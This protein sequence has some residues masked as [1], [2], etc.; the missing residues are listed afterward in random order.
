MRALKEVSIFLLSVIL[1]CY[2]NIS[3]PAE[4]QCRVNEYQCPREVTGECGLCIPFQW[5]CDGDGDCNGNADEEGCELPTCTPEQFACGNGKCIPTTWV[6]DTDNDCGDSTD[7]SGCPVEECEDQYFNCANNKCV[8]EQW[9]CDGDDDCGDGSDENCDTTCTPAEF[10]CD[11][12]GACLP[13]EWKCDGDRDCQDGSDEIDCSHVPT[14]CLHGQYQCTMG[15]CILLHYVCDGEP[16][17]PKDTSDEDF[18]AKETC[19]DDEF[20]CGDYTCIDIGWQCDGEYDCED[21][22]DEVDCPDKMCLVTQ[23][24]CASG[25]CISREWRCD[26]ENDCTD[27]S[28]EK[29]CEKNCSANQFQCANSLCIGVQKVCNSQDDCGDGSDELPKNE[30]NIYDPLVES[31]EE[32]NG[33]CDQICEDLNPEPGVRCSCN[34]G[35]QL[36]AN[37]TSCLDIDECQ[38]EGICSQ[39]CRNT[40]G[41]FKCSCVEGYLLRPDGLT[42]KAKGPEPYLLFANRIDIRRIEPTHPKNSAILK[43]LENAIALDY[44]IG[45]QLVF[46]SDV[47]LDIIKRVHLNESAVLD[48][49][50]TGLESPGGLAVDW[51]T[52]KLYWTDSGTSRIEVANL[53]GSM[54][55]VLIWKNLERPR[56]LVV[57]PSK[58]TMYWT[59]WGSTPKIE[60]AAM[61]GKRRQ[62]IADTRLYWPNGLTLDYTNNKLYWVDAK[63][64]IIES[65]NLDGSRRKAVISQGLPHPFAITVFED[66]IYWTDWHTKSISMANKFT[67]NNLETIQSQLH[68]PMDIHSFHPQRQPNVVNRCGDN[69]GGCS[70]LCLL[71][72]DAYTC[73]CPTGYRKVNQTTC[74]QTIDNFLVFTKGTDIRRISFDTPDMTDMVIPLTD[75]KDAVALDWDSNAD[76]IFW[77]DTVMDTISRA[78]WDGSEQEVIVS[79]GLQSPA[80]LAVDWFTH[81]LYW[82]EAGADH[83]EVSN[84]DGSMRS[85]LLWKHLDRPRDI[86]VDPLSGYMYWT[87]WGQIPKI[88]CAGMDGSN[89]HILVTDDLTWPNGLALDVTKEG[90]K[91]DVHFLYWTDAGTKKIERFNLDTHHRMAILNDVNHPFGLIVSGNRIYW[92]DWDT[93]KIES[94]NKIT[95]LEREVIASELE[96]LMDIHVFH[97]NRTETWSPCQNNNG[98][99]S[100]LCLMT[101]TTR[102]YSCACPTGVVLSEDRRT[103]KPGMQNFLIFARR[104]DIRTISLDV[105]YKADVVIPLGELQNAIAVDVD[106]IEGKVY[107]TDSLE[108]KIQRANLNGSNVEGVITTNV[109]VTDGLAIDIAGRKMYWTDT[110][111]HRIEVANLDGTQ[112]KVLIWE[113]LDSPRDIELHHQQ[114]WMYWSDWGDTPKIERAWMNGEGRETIIDTGLGWPNSITIDRETSKIYWNDA[115]TKRIEMADLDGQNRNILIRKDVPHPYGL[116]LSNNYVYWT[117]WQQKTIKRA[118]KDTGGGVVTIADNLDGL[119]AIHAINMS[120]REENMCGTNNGGCSDLCLPTPEGTRC[121]CP[122]GIRLNED[123]RT[124]PKYPKSFLLFASQKY[125]HRISME[126][127]D[128]QDVVLPITD[129]QNAVAVDFYSAEEKIYFTDVYHDEIR[130]ANYNGSNVETVVSKLGTSDG[131]AIDWMAKNLYW[132]DTDNNKIEVARLDG[133]ARKTII[134]NNLD[135]PRA[136]ALFPASG[137]LFWSDWGHNPKIERSYFDG[138]NRK[139]L[140]SSNL[141]WPNGLTVDYA[142]QMIYWTDAHMDKIETANLDGKNRQLLSSLNTH[143]SFG[144]TLYGYRLYWTDWSTQSIESVHK[145]TGVDAQTIQSNMVE[146]LMG[147]S[148]VSP[149]RQLGSNPCTVENGLCTHLCLARPEGYICACPDEPDERPCSSTPGGGDLI[150]TTTT[151]KSP[152]TSLAVSTDHPTTVITEAATTTAEKDVTTKHPNV[153]PEDGWRTTKI[154]SNTDQQNEVGNAICTLE[155]EEGGLCQRIAEPSKR[156]PDKGIYMFVIIGIVVLLVLFLLL[157]LFI[158]WRRHQT[159]DRCS[160]DPTLAYGLPRYNH[161][162]NEVTI[163]PRCQTRPWQYYDKQTP[164][165]ITNVN[166]VVKLNNVEEASRMLPPVAGACFSDGDLLQKQDNNKLDYDPPKKPLNVDADAEVEGACA[167]PERNFDENNYDFDEK[168]YEFDEKKL[169]YNDDFR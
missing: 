43:D 98:G 3:D 138:T 63:H 17:C 59:D 33:G 76:H 8:R 155:M 1:G 47:T 111:K 5:H 13:M 52:H 12:G 105:D 99:C 147:I 91:M 19:R 135:E 159:R 102:R 150:S 149:N 49:V 40:P 146:G 96:N 84:L 156:N 109:N 120:R 151:T 81:K 20:Q 125:M 29:G 114:G 27:H 110:G 122:T 130:R 103:C 16:D 61:D 144:L 65:A 112:R 77:T 28:D 123:G 18:C 45:E 106:V 119:M 162:T 115:L 143:H 75:L 57:H 22:T 160:Q 60:S 142:S 165:N 133:A 128:Y 86:I 23:F 93:K 42:C 141:M 132:T 37:G 6:C 121:A 7:E 124:C 136:I 48:V 89:R 139:T 129:I 26:G 68:F 69:N 85:I 164:D 97:R 161:I 31:C 107:W 148:M 11:G 2:G 100:H 46:W 137:Y 24:Q 87:D 95:G 58:G 32:E 35:Y 108:K 9:V 113:D 145:L 131:I 30:C 55:S 88:E 78:K 126:T 167:L 163:L 50:N 38:V 152:P 94:A 66:S 72:I 39:D 36:Q 101:Y 140:V 73:A 34:N 56:A 15:N 104:M 21:S 62:V 51:V 41:S 154:S 169:D 134:E 4:C 80:G 82:T 25:R 157:L 153:I 90:E 71:N 14:V 54:R 64:H 67:G 116:T 92:T 117:D 168:T 158:V 10:T 53:D 83:I 166:L 44:H 127:E 74:A 70:H 118:R 79:S